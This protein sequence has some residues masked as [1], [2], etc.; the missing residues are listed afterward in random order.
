M[1]AKVFANIKGISNDEW[2]ALRKAGIGGSDVSAI[3]GLSRWRSPLDIYFDKIYE[4]NPYAEDISDKPYIIAGH[5]LEPVIAQ[6]F[7]EV[8]GLK[9]KNR[10]AMLQHPDYPW[11]LANVDRLIVGEKVGLECKN[12]NQYKAGEW[13]DGEIPEE[14]I[15]QCQHYMAV[16]GY[17]GWWIAVLIGGWD[18]RYKYIERDETIIQAL[19][20]E[21]EYFWKEHVLKQVPPPIDGSEASKKMMLKMYPESTPRSEISLNVDEYLPVL[22][23]IEACDNEIAE[24]QLRKNKYIHELQEVIG[25]NEVA[26]IGERKISWKTNSPKTTLDKDRL[27]KENPRQY[28]YYMKLFEKFKKVG[29]APRPFKI[30]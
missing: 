15:L 16:T 19:I 24:I 25:E 6:W 28:Q 10:Y 5:K 8:T 17:K 22:D 29:K 21:E 13:A 30:N 20:E 14:Y 11:M 3:L 7:S 23:A 27:K 2:L 26:Y 9:V 12:A 1:M 4:E 18:F